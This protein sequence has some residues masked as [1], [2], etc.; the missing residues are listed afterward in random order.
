MLHKGTRGVV[1][2][3]SRVSGEFEITTGVRQGDLLAPTLFNLFFDSVISATLACHPHCGVK[4]LYNLD[5]ELVGSRKKMRGSVVIQDLVYAD[6]MVVICGSMDALEEVL[7]SLEAVCSGVGLSISSR[8]IKGYG[9][10]SLY[11]S[12]SSSSTSTAETR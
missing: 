4:M 9:Y 11:L 7:R 3:Y 12:L 8:K 6:N 10:M 2:A 1:R 5:D